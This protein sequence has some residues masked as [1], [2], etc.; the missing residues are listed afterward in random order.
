MTEIPNSNEWTNINLADPNSFPVAGEHVE[1]EYANGLYTGYIGN[2]AQGALCWL[3]SV[4]FRCDGP[5]G[6]PLRWRLFDPEES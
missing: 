3:G 5:I 1:M 6:E 4:D 2:W